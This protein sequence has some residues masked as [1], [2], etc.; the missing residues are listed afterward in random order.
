MTKKGLDFDWNKVDPKFKPIID[1]FCDAEGIVDA[2]D[3]ELSQMQRNYVAA[4]NTY[5]IEDVLR[6]LT[7]SPNIIED[8]S[9]PLF[10]RM[11]RDIA[12]KIIMDGPDYAIKSIKT[13]GKWVEFWFE[14]EPPRENGGWHQCCKQYMLYEVVE[15]AGLN[16]HVLNHGFK[17]LVVTWPEGSDRPTAIC[18]PDDDEV[19]EKS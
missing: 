5:F 14:G 10:I 16:D 19:D 12:D 4:A 8:G 1:A 6:E 15:N 18:N 17:G 13:S 7:S 3:S 11:D 9:H 2:D